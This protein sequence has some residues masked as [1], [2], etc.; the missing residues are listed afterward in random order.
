MLDSLR[1]KLADAIA[2]QREKMTVKENDNTFYI[3]DNASGLYRDRFEYDRATILSE[4]LRAWRVSPLARTLVNL[5]TQFI[6]GEGYTIKCDHPATHKFLQEW[7]NHPLNNLNQQI[8]EWCDERTRSGNLFPLITAVPDGMT[9]IRM[10]PSELIKDI[11]SADN[12]IL[13][14]TY[15]IPVMEETPP[16]KAYNPLEPVMQAGA[17]SVS[18]MRHYVTNRPVGVVWGEPDLAPL[19]PWI[20]RYSTWLEDRVRLNHFRS[21]FMYVVRGV[22]KSEEERKR[23]ENEINANP[24]KPGSVLVTNANN[25]EDWGILSATLDAFDAAMDGMALKKMIALGWNI[26]MHY[27]AE[28][29]SSTRTTAEASGTPTF[30]MLEKKQKEFTNM[31]LDLARIAVKVRKEVDRRVKPEAEITIAA[32]DITERD[33]SNLALAAS[34][35]EPVLADLYDREMIDEN[36]VLTTTYAMMGEVY[37]ASKNNMKG[38]GKRRPLKAT[39]GSQPSADIPKEPDPKT[40]PLDTGSEE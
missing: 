30:R 32:G 8:P 33:N 12:D 27:L 38:K 5:N 14:E 11:Q 31:L 24:P 13:Q 16:W 2:P 25:G 7:W 23:R 29:E 15:Y 35:V 3:G 36:Q 6:V 4:C 21:V 40:N 19:L 20:G 34:R 18:F 26:P 1:A 17:E 39:Q 28:P 10:V 9:Y 22:F 37:D